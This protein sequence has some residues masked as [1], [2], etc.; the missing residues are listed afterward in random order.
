MC[1]IQSMLSILVVTN[2]SHFHLKGHGQ[3]WLLIGSCMN[4]QY[5]LIDSTVYLWHFWYSFNL[6]IF[7]LNFRL[8]NAKY[9]R[10]EKF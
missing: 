10:G 8:F 3:S 9:L 2:D 6:K 1:H 7:L 4:F 5:Y